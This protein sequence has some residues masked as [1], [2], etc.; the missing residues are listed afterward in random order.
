[1]SI[2]DYFAEVKIAASRD[3]SPVLD[4]YKANRPGKRRKLP[5]VPRR[6]HPPIPLL[7]CLAIALIMRAWL[8]IHT[9]GFINGDEALVGI[10][11]EHIL[12]GEFPIYF[13]HQ[14]YMG[15]LE[16]YLMALIFAIVG[17]S[18]WAL[19]AEPILVSL[20]VVWLTWKLAAELA[21]T[22]H[23]P[24]YAQR[25]FMT[26]SALLAAIPPLYDT[27]LELT[28]LGGY[29][30]SFVLM[31]LLL[32]SVLKITRRRRAG[33]SVREL[34]WRWAS[35]GFIVG[36]GFW[37][38]PIIIYAIIA[39]ALW[40]AWDCIQLVRHTR[41]GKYFV[42]SVAV[43]S[44][45]ALPACIVGLIPALIWGIS[46]SWQNIT[47]MLY[48]QGNATLRP[49]ILAQYPTRL[50]I[51]TGLVQLYT[52]CVTPRIISGA[53][54]GESSLLRLLH[55]P[56]L[57]FGVFCILTTGALFVASLIHS[58]PFLLRIRKIAG[59]PLLFAASVTVIFCVTKTA[60]PGLWAC[61]YDLAGRY[62]TPLM[63]VLPFLL[64]TPFT[65]LVLLQSDGYRGLTLDFKKLT[66][67]GADSSARK[68]HDE[69]ARR[70]RFIASTADLSAPSHD[71][72]IKAP[73]EDMT[74]Y[75]VDPES[76]S[77]PAEWGAMNL[78]P[79][80]PALVR[81]SLGLLVG[82]LLLALYMQVFSYGL[83]DAG[84]TFQSPYCTFASVNN[85]AI[86]AYMEREHIQ[87]AW[88]PSWIAYP[89]VFKTQS[90]II[91]ADPLPFILN[92]QAGNRIPANSDAVL[93][94][95]RPSL[96][97]FVRHTDRY[98]EILQ[99]LDSK[100]VTYRTARFPAQEGRDVIVVT[101]LN[102]T[103]SPLES[104]SFFNIF[105]CS[106]DS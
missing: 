70:G 40:I 103:V 97:T 58:S 105:I 12:H 102:R 79:T 60:A 8:T 47:Y 3:D 18:A 24:R 76:T 1:M 69:N 7:C 101:P 90:R 87:Y 15:S 2:K 63:L 19:R 37:I 72:L 81:A 68:I 66:W 29:I 61:Q 6:I 31:L 38:N 104:G 94:A 4:V 33:A 51:F 43:P 34:S 23:L 13:Y 20:A 5:D 46:N 27:V 54:P 52:T 53:L 95:D 25:W 96:I 57:Y 44:I 71:Y 77:S 75:P 85:D 35:V 99:L 26:I 83:T 73:H 10:Q 67:G 56:M 100:H 42:H 17:P 36:F 82:I 21:E 93:H 89:I 98:P 48:L 55:T 30:E 50:D 65:A 59:L 22:A 11:A 88:A 28:T 39:A 45:S 84:S 91:L 106:R 86:I 92:N 32:L 49:E 9:Q 64:A 41:T 14:P 80:P 62:A 78:A 16:A 74:T